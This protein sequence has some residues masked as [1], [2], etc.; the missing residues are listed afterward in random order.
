MAVVSR[1]N[2]IAIPAYGSG[3]RG[4]QIVTELFRQFLSGKS[5]KPVVAQN[6]IEILQRILLV[7]PGNGIDYM[8]LLLVAS[9]KPSYFR[10]SGLIRLEKK[11]YRDG[12]ADA[13]IRKSIDV[14]IADVRRSPD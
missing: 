13:G 5:T 7:R 3:E 2:L 8:L 10:R 1:T 9:A 14:N 6:S 12:N 11:R 4:G